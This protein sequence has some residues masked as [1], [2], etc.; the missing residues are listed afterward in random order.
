MTDGAVT[1]L[2]ET[3]EAIRK[4]SPSPLSIVIV[5]IGDADFS[6]MQILVDLQAND[7]G[8][9]RDTVQFVEFNKYRYDQKAL[10]KETLAKIPHQV[11]RYFYGNGV[12]PHPAVA[13]GTVNLFE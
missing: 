12:M 2:E 4:A 7:G 1:D 3:K 8:R 13:G 5:G 9:N 11:V 6:Q 10:A